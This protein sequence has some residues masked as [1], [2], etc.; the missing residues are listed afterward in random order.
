MYL[1]AGVMAEERMRE[2]AALDELPPMYSILNGEVVSVTTYGAF[3]KIPGYKKQG[4]VH[5]SEMSSCRVENPAEIVDVGEQV[6][7]KV[8]GREMKDDKVK[9]SFSMKSVNQGTGR[10]LDP[11][12]VIAEQDERRRRQFRDHTEQKIT[13]KI[14][15]KYTL[16]TL[17]KTASPSLDCSTV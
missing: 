16:V 8:I 14:T 1:S 4:L 2:P 9:L 11:N 15:L 13:Q 3:V 6:W 17:Q 7:I 12:N 5:K 10:D